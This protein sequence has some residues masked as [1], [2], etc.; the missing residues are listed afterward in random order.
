[1]SKVRFPF[2]VPVPTPPPV[3]DVA[4]Q[5]SAIYDPTSTVKGENEERSI[6]LF[7][8]FVADAEADSLLRVSET[9]AKAVEVMIRATI[10]HT[11]PDQTTNSDHPSSRPT[12]NSHRNF[13][14]PCE[15]R[16]ESSNP[17][18]PPQD[19]ALFLDFDLSILAAPRSKYEDY[20]QSIRLEYDHYADSDYCAG[21]TAVLH[22]FLKREKLFFSTVAE[23]EGWDHRARENLEYEIS[24]LNGGELTQTDSPGGSKDTNFRR[25]I[26]ERS[27][28][29]K[30]A[31][32]LA[33]NN[34]EGAQQTNLDC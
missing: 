33:P 9:D 29:W 30:D 12:S 5:D 4:D 11:I 3:V 16:E 13:K 28:G 25:R 21:R 6:A 26:D 15:A 27:D 20:M 1:M 31:E 8:E 17:M 34:D 10:T 19:I 23:K 18:V 24:V 32:H 2:H 22:G 14:S 7:K